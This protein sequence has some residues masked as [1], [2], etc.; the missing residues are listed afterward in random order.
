M[1]GLNKALAF[2]I[3][4]NLAA[5]SSAFSPSAAAKRSHV[6]L[7]MSSDDDVVLDVAT[8]NAR[9]MTPLSVIAASM[10][11]LST[12]VSPA[13][14]ASSSPFEAGM[15]KSFPGSLPNS[16]VALRVASAL[17]DRGYTDTN[18]LFGSSLCSDEIND[19]A[20]SIV[21]DLQ[22][23][24]QVDG[25]FNLGGLGGLPFV[26]ITGMGAFLSHCPEQGKVFIVFGPHVGIDARGVVGTVERIGQDGPHTSC[27]A[28]IGAYKAIMGKPM[29]DE[30]MAFIGTKDFQEEY[31]IAK[32]RD[33][34]EILR[35]KDPSDE[36]ITYVTNKMYD[37]VWE[38]LR[39]EINA[40]TTKDGFWKNT[41]EV[42][43]L[44]GIVV[45]RGHG[46]GTPG[47]EDFF[48]PLMLKTLT[49]AGE[50]DLYGEVFGDFPALAAPHRNAKYV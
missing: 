47:G 23:K 36:T 33:R 37:L 45:N 1:L 38:M 41:S 3:S 7:H 40:Y 11:P 4:V 35:G 30:D 9:I 18:T 10:A 2:L 42:T 5:Q 6:Q 39:G 16:A 26:G 24:L 22:N 48:Q 12:I 15:K 46:Q 8:R 27:G 17:K 43:L 29:T 32:L 25:V 20:D 31:I 44:G 50:T 49:Q 34:L 21:A 19:T 13:N 14:A 28:G